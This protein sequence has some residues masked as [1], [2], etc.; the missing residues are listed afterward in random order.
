MKT[1]LIEDR[2]GVCDALANTQ[3]TGRPHFHEC[4]SESS[5]A[6]CVEMIEAADRQFG[7][8]RGFVVHR[9][10][11]DVAFKKGGQHE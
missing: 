5:A 10:G 2:R 6:A 1:P 3:N 7:I 9:D 4:K 8:L 11:K